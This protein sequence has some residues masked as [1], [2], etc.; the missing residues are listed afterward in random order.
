MLQAEQSD[1]IL[2]RQAFIADESDILK[3][4]LIASTAKFLSKQGLGV[5]STS[6]SGVGADAP[7]VA[8]SLSGG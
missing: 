7:V 8:V 6:V 5:Q 1:E 2:E 3:S 4:P